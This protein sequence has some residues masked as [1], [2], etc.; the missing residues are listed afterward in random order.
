[1]KT[2]PRIL[3]ISALVLSIFLIQACSDKTEDK[4]STGDHVWKTQTESLEK[5]Q[6][7]DQILQNATAEH[8]QAIEDQTQ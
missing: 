7:V 1:M 8:R 4:G 6:Q 2:A 3:K 5:A